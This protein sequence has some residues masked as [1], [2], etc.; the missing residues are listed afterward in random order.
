MRVAVK[1]FILLPKIVRVVYKLRCPIETTVATDDYY[2]KSRIKRDYR[3]SYYYYFKYFLI[4]HNWHSHDDV[5]PRVPETA[6]RRLSCLIEGLSRSRL[7]GVFLSFIRP[8]CVRVR[9]VPPPRSM[10]TSCPPPP[11][12][13]V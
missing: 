2:T 12:M 5:G 10:E 4:V 11:H 3:K 6:R 1:T 7:V 13:A 9:V 8:V